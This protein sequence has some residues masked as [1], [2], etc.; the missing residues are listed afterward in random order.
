[1]KK[2]I[3]ILIT[4]ITIVLALSVSAGAVDIVNGDVNRDDKFDVFDV[5]ALKRIVLGTYEGNYHTL[6]AADT[7]HNG[8]VDA[9]TSF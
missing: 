6:F 5:L 3:A 9:I 7:D 1:M 8:V 4:A 2:I